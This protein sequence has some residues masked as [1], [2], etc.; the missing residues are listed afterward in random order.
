[1][2]YTGTRPTPRD[3]GAREG[4]YRATAGLMVLRNAMTRAVVRLK[5]A[6]S[7]VRIGS[8]KVIH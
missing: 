4:S 8:V 6:G 5:R 2:P 7:R 3:R 1:M